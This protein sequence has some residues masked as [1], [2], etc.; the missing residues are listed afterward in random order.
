MRKLFP[1]MQIA[2]HMNKMKNEKG[3]RR[4]RKNTNQNI[5]KQRRKE[6]PGGKMKD[7]MEGKKES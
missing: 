5:R 2:C 4:G 6:E 1:M 3:I 7:K